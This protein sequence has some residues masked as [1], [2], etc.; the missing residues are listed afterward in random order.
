MKRSVV[1]LPTLATLL[2]SA[3]L[4]V[5]VASAGAPAFAQAPG[6]AGTAGRIIRPNAII[7][8]VSDLDRSTAFYRDAVG[9]ELDSSP[10]LPSGSS[11]QMGLLMNAPG[12][13]VRTATFKIPGTEV[14]LVLMQV[15]KVDGRK[16]VSRIQDPG[17]VKLVLRVRDMDTQFSRVRDR[18]TGVYTSGGGP[19]RPE[20][21]NG[22]NQAVITK[23][24]DGCALEF[25]S[26]P[27][28][29]LADTLP[30]DS[31]VVGGWGSFVVADLAKTID[32]YRGSLGFAINGSGRPASATLL[33]LEGTPQATTTVSTGSR[34][35]GAAYTWFMYDFRG[36]ERNTLPTRLQ[37]PGTAAVSFL[38]DDVGALVSRL[39]AGG[40]RVETTG[41]EP[42]MV[43]G[44]RRVFVR[45][46]SGILLE[47]VEA[48]GDGQ[49]A[50][51]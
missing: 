30:A 37:D 41:G 27:N 13:E 17:V 1:R 32:F 22:R 33:A 34:P 23:D 18:I 7:H 47:F 48:H 29:P 42:V 26:Q 3:T 16:I 46:P 28:P 51:R 36:I 20:G 14:R 2:A 4:S 25:V 21:P 6:E 40:T 5:L 50:A 43:N 9:L 45:D 8:T 49:A 12:A 31:N 38:V 11:P 24:P 19:I 15:S 10:A 39:K 44:E 35:P